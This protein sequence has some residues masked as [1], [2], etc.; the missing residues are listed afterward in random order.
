M[1]TK[2]NKEQFFNNVQKKINHRNAL[3][4]FYINVFLPIAKKF[5][6]KVYNIRFIKALR[7][8]AEKIS[9]CIFIGEL[10]DGYIEINYRMGIFSY[11]DFEYAYYPLPLNENGRI[12]YEDCVNKGFDAESFAKIT[13]EY[14][15]SLDNYDKYME[16]ADRLADVVKE[17]NSLP[18]KFRSNIDV[19]LHIY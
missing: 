10:M 15:N 9:K 8:E 1:R 17:Y 4:D 18:Y 6:G 12:S 16:I 2:M 14:Q 19:N 5:D 7:G 13:N 3:N 11:S